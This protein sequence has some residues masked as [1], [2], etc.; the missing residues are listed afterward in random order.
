MKYLKCNSFLV[1]LSGGTGEFKFSNGNYNYRVRFNNMLK[2]F[3]SMSS[4]VQDLK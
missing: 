3:K 4:D 1:L 2:V